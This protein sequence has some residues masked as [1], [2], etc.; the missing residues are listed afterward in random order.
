MNR[1]EHKRPDRVVSVHFPK[2]AGSSLKEQFVNLLGDLVYL[3]YAR[4]PLAVDD[5]HVSDFPEGKAIVHGHFPAA[6]YASTSAYMITFLREPIDNLISNYF[7]WNT[8]EKPTNQLHARFLDER[9]SLL[10]FAS[11]PKIRRLMSETYFG[12]IDLNRLDFVGFYDNRDA[13][14][15]RLSNVLELPLDPL[16]H[17][18]RTKEYPNRSIVMQNKNIIKELENLLSDDISFYWN[19][20]RKFGVF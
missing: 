13:D 11:Y 15:I 1:S 17:L 20:R 14:M 16:L 6:R 8:F 18:N 7:Y 10:A 5:L 12:N 2:A 3:D 19:A 4:G 9:P